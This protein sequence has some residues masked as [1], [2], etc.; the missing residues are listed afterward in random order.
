MSPK[1][2]FLDIDGTILKHMGSLSNILTQ[3]KQNILEGV[4]TKLNEWESKRYNIILTTGRKESMRKFTE[5]QLTQLGIFWD[6]LIMGLGGGPRI[7]I[8]DKKPDGTETCRAINLD[9]NK[10]LNDV[11]I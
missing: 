8:N 4:L 2:I 11:E 5:D 6:Q 7:I 10:G 1:T 3:K 9:R